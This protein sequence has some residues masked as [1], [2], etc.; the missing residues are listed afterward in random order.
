MREHKEI[1]KTSSH[2]KKRAH[3]ATFKSFRG[4]LTLAHEFARNN[5]KGICNILCDKIFVFL[6]T[7]SG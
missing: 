2:D 4:I 5:E 3:T 1:L 7:P 6:Y